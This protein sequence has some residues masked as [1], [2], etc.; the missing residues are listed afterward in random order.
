MSPVVLTLVLTV[1]LK[2]VHAFEFLLLLVRLQMCL[3]KSNN[4]ND[5][6]ER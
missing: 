2:A 6:K 3:Q 5:S 4:S 1:R